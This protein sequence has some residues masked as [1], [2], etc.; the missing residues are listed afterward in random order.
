MFT[1]IF[2]MTFSASANEQ[3]NLPLESEPNEIG[4]WNAQNRKLGQVWDGQR[5]NSDLLV[6]ERCDAIEKYLESR[7]KVENL[8]HKLGELAIKITLTTS[9]QQWYTR[10]LILAY[11]LRA[12][13][14]QPAIV[15]YRERW[16]RTEY[17]WMNNVLSPKQQ[18][19]NKLIKELER[20]ASEED[21]KRAHLL[22]ALLAVEQ[23]KLQLEL[24]TTNNIAHWWLR[25]ITEREELLKKAGA[26]GRFSAFDPSNPQRCH[27]N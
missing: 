22:S 9:Y 10:D 4:M 11:Q 17:Q 20:Y 8:E 18:K 15:P 24:T 26:Q 12:M 1:L 21:E 13:Y 6:R 2:A 27:A 19:L 25:E 16:D 14:E 5:W 23:P 3:E 7:D